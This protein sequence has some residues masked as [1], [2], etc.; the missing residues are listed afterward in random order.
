MIARTSVLLIALAAG[1]CGSNEAQNR[2]DPFV[3]PSDPY[4]Q[5]LDAVF[6][7]RGC[8]KPQDRRVITTIDRLRG[9]ES[10]AKSRGL[11]RYS[12]RAHHTF[13]VSISDVL[14]VLCQPDYDGALREANE[15][16]E[17]LRQHIENLS[18]ADS[19]SR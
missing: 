6:N 16:I 1:S 3:H 15:K 9:T 17:R 14:R 4:V 13:E 12:A 2:A 11:E 18:S 8:Q 5:A 19:V 7:L 10:L